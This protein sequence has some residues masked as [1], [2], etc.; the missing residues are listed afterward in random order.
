MESKRVFGNIVWR[1]L[2]RFGAQGVSFVVSIILARLLDPELYGTIALVTVFTTI[3]QVFID[4]GLGT[5]LIQKKDADSKDFSTVFY[6][7]IAMC[8]VLYSVMFVSAPLIAGFY[9]LPELVPIVRV[10]S[11]SLV[12]SGVKNIQQSYVSRNMLFKRFFYSTIGSTVASAIVGIAMAYK[13]FGV[14][15]LVGQTLTSNI[16]G[17]VILWL[18]V[19]W[20]P[21]LEFSFERLKGLFSFGWKLLVSALLETVYKDLRSLLIGK[22]YTSADLAYYDR[23]HYIPSLAITN[24]NTSI[25]SVLLPAMSSEQ[26]DKDRVKAMTRR[27]IK[28]STYIIMPMMVG[29]AVCSEPLITLLLT[30][31]WLPSVFFLRIFCITYAFYPIHTANLNAI[32]AMGRSDLF[33]KLEIIKKIVGLVALFSTIFVSVRAMAYSMLVTTFT[34]QI[35]NSWPNKKLLKYSYIEQ[36]KDMLPQILLSCFMGLCVFGISFIG[37]NDI[38]TLVLQVLLGVVIYVVG[39]FVLKLESFKYL[40]SVFKKFTSKK[41]V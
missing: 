15:A 29:L 41:R 6:F 37:L 36:I 28:T 35:I 33:L 14:W 39:S 2:E 17:T 34:S 30:E 27:A 1:L 4:S 21:T 7:N 31:K 22:L 12:V 38:L 26:D 32:K 8:L 10:L 23:G 24:I 3:M 16:A 11:L 25:D 13:G 18:T 5:A 9:E 20:R 40:L 19:R